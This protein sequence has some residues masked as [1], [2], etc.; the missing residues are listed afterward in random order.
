MLSNLLNNAI[1]FTD[2]GGVV[3]VE[4]DRP[5]EQIRFQIKDSGL[6]IPAD[7]IPHVFER[8]WRARHKQYL[9]AGLG[10]YIAKSIINAHGGKIGVESEAGKGSA[11][12]FFLSPSTVSTDQRMKKTA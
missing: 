9:G 11:F 6:G 8:F 5:K 10:L 12:F 1:K 4:V 2:S 7:Q 3:H